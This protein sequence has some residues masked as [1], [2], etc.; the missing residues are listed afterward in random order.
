MFVYKS[1][2]DKVWVKLNKCV[3]SLNEDLYIC[4]CYVTPDDSSRRTLVE[5]NRPLSDRRGYVH[6]SYF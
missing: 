5:S 1:E 6:F 2:E 4:L 3:L